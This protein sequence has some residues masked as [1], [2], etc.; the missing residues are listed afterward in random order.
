[1]TEQDAAALCERAHRHLAHPQEQ[2]DNRL[3]RDLLTAWLQE[4]ERRVLAEDTRGRAQAD[5]NRAI[6]ERRQLEAD[7]RNLARVLVMIS[8]NIEATVQRQKIPHLVAVDLT[9]PADTR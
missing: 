5:A 8:E 9:P 6:E 1:M 2:A 7:A 4:R 3:V